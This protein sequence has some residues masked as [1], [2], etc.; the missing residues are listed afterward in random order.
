MKNKIVLKLQL[1]TLRAL[2]ISLLNKKKNTY[3]SL[4]PLHCNLQPSEPLGLLTD[5]HIIVLFTESFE[6]AMFCTSVQS[7]E[8]AS[9]KFL[10]EKTV[11]RKLMWPVHHIIPTLKC[12]IITLHPKHT[13]MHLSSI[14]CMYTDICRSIYMCKNTQTHLPIMQAVQ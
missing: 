14:Y 8:K 5:K 12:F 1:P 13:H 2:L 6:D 4:T 11:T 10:K 7:F 9:R 3:S